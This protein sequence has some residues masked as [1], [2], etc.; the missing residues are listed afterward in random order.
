MH[1][2]FSF[3]RVSI[4]TELTTPF[5]RVF[6]RLLHEGMCTRV[7]PYG[8]DKSGKIGGHPAQDLATQTG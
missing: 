4:R 5:G 7:V 6:R 1:S 8:Y 2:H 3:L